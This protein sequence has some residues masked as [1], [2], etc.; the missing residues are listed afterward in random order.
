MGQRAEVEELQGLDGAGCHM[1]ERAPGSWG[2]GR[3]SGEG[4]QGSWRVQPGR[5]LTC[6]LQADRG[7]AEVPDAH[8]AGE[9]ALIGHAHA[10]QPQGRIALGQQVGEEGRAVGVRAALVPALGEAVHQLLGVRQLPDEVELRQAEAGFGREGAA[11]GGIGAHQ[12]HHGVLG[13]LDLH[14][15]WGTQSGPVRGQGP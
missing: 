15:A 12:G 3:H 13:H 10:L 11:Q 14:G 2:R 8:E 5:V 4:A 6:H 9:A 1:G 7:A